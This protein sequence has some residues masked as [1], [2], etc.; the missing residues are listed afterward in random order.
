MV[1]QF[2][3][4][5]N[6]FSLVLWRMMLYQSLNAHER[7]SMVHLKKWSL[8]AFLP[9]GH[10][11]VRGTALWL[12]LPCSTLGLDLDLANIYK[13]LQEPHSMQDFDSEARTYSRF[14]SSTVNCAWNLLESFI[15][16]S[17]DSIW[18]FIPV[19]GCVWEE[20]HLMEI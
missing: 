11:G 15:L 1:W 4:F 16:V 6:V 2:V 7:N 17:V 12:Y 3:P 9:L 14:L 8:S 19:S 18:Q 20:R 13:L 10:Y 5:I